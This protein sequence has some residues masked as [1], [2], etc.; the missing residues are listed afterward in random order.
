MCATL[1]AMETSDNTIVHLAPSSVLYNG[2]KV[3]NREEFAKKTQL[4]A[5]VANMQYSKKD[6]IQVSS[7]YVSDYAKEY[8]ILLPPEKIIQER[9]YITQV[10]IFKSI[11]Y[12][13][14]VQLK[15]TTRPLKQTKSKL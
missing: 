5:L 9:N 10:L 4:H 12:Q 6:L 1:S 7:Y 2:L 15:K 13:Q 3:A 14:Y 8:G 11:A